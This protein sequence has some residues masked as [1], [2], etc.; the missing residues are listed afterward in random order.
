[1]PD[2]NTSPQAVS[3]TNVDHIFDHKLL[4]AET[5]QVA[6]LFLKI[7]STYVYQETDLQ[8]IMTFLEALIAKQYEYIVVLDVRF[9][10]MQYYV[11]YFEVF[12]KSVADLSSSN[13]R[14]MTVLIPKYMAPART[15]IEKNVATVSSVPLHI[16][17]I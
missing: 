6:S 12:L 10:K 17:C 13:V 11:S 2:T 7:R 14:H 4:P 8:N 5:G 15:F 3:D 16:K 1:M 9:L